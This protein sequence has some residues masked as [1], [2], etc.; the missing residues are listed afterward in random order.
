MAY[1][2]T[3]LFVVLPFILTV[4]NTLYNLREAIDEDDVFHVVVFHAIFFT[5]YIVILIIT[6]AFFF[7]FK[8]LIG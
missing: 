1:L 2:L 5:G 4:G 7:V 8:A 6:V 3:F